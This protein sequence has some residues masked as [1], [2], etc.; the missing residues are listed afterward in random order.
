[1]RAVDS[2]RVPDE[3]QTFL[4]SVDLFEGLSDRDLAAIAG[5]MRR[6]EFHAG[7]SIVTEGE[8][9]VGFFVVESG[10]ATVRR[11]EREV[12]KL[13][14]GSSFGEVAVLAGGHRS[15]SVVA[16]GDLTCLAMTAWTFK[17]MVRSHPTIAFK[18]LERMAHQL[19][20]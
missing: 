19:A 13:T 7:D 15:A 10:S 16:D 14:S 3:T 11:G 6:R 5:T 8:G 20:D 17:P 1:M 12:A 2:A 18:L 9:G 4:K